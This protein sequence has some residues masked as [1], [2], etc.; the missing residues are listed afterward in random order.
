MA[1]QP[2]EIDVESLYDKVRGQD[3]SH[4]PKMMQQ[5]FSKDIPYT[6]EKLLAHLGVKVVDDS[7]VENIQDVCT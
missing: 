5:V 6:R 2:T 4:I 7:E 3:F 1:P